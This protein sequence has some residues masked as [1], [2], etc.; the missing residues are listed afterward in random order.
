METMSSA[1]LT[2]SAKP[3]K[4]ASD[5]PL[6]PRP[7]DASATPITP[8]VGAGVPAD[9]LDER[10]DAGGG[11]REQVPQVALLDGLLDPAP[12]SLPLG[13]A[14]HVLELTP[15]ERSGPAVAPAGA[16]PARGAGRSRPASS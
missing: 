3:V 5:D 15:R 11:V 4:R 14:A 6:G 2:G 8:L 12:Q 1:A 13:I 16:A 9:V 7:S 10:L